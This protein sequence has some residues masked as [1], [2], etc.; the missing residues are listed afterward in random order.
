[1]INLKAKLQQILSSRDLLC[2]KLC[3]KKECELKGFEIYNFV[4]EN[5]QGA[6]IG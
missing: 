2:D 4:Y 3:E 5:Y 6:S 1:M